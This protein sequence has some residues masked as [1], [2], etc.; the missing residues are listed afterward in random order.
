[1]PRTPPPRPTAWQTRRARAIVRWYLDAY[2][3]TP[4]DMGVASTFMDPSRV[5]HFAVNREAFEAGDPAALFKILV[6]TAMFQ[7][8]SDQQIL[9]VLRGIGE[10]DAQELSSAPWLLAQARGSA[11]PALESTDTLRE[12]CDLAKD[13][14]RRGTCG[15]SPGAA[16]HL[17]RH[18]ELLKRYG[19][20]GKVPTS[21]A[22]AVAEAGVNDLA[23]L[24]A[25]VLQ[26]A[27]E[28]TE[29]AVMLQSALC[30]A[31][32]VSEKISAMFLSLVCTP[33]LC[34]SVVPPWAEGVDWTQFVVVDSNVDLFLRATGYPGPW[35]YEARRMFLRTLAR[36]V[37]LAAMK[38]GLR[39]FNPRLVQQALYLFMSASNRRVS[40]GDCSSGGAAACRACRVE[41]RKVCAWGFLK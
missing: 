34:P 39:R 3:G 23:E 29:A 2:H 16:C 9:R 25:R 5:G 38:P 37:D 10:A 35:T 28:P 40:R 14:Q 33:D 36:R 6:A 4:W 20:F 19:H 32:R 8:R 27:A 15:R 22:L 7:K 24:R 21:I 26:D 1:M 30:K 12:Q 17:K 18:T 11:C 13:Q 41:L 31:W